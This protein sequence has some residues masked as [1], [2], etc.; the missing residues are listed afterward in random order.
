MKRFASS[1]LI[2]VLSVATFAAIAKAE[3]KLSSFEVVTLAYQGRL[4][5]NGIPGYASLE[6]NVNFGTITAEDIIEAAIASGHLAETSLEDST[7]I[8]EVERHLQNLVENN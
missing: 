6:A 4:T 2:L 8:A 5:E 7:F 3:T 1:L